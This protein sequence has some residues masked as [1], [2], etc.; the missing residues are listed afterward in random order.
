[1]RHLVYVPEFSLGKVQG[2]AMTRL[3]SSN[4]KSLFP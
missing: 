2:S 4:M 3:V 1:M